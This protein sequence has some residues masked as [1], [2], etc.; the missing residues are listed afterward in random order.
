MTNNHV[1]EGC[2]K[3]E[4]IRTGFKSDAEVVSLDAQ[5]DLA[6]LRSEKSNI[7]SLGF[8]PNNKVRIGENIIV[9]GY[10]LGDLLGSSIKLTSGNIS[11]MTGLIN[12]STTMQL[13]A[14]VQ[15]G[16][17]GGPL[18]DN[19]GQIIGVIFAKLAHQKELNAENINLAIKS[20]IVKMFLDT[21]DISYTSLP[22]E[23]PKEI[24]DIADE[25]KESI[26]RINCYQ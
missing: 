18:L 23:S 8:R 9:L 16:N 25:A 4:L 6:I 13:T 11:S 19:R 15:P 22:V 17:S 20:N 10:P 2:K 12:D 14:P 21:H 3:I 7:K 26:V 1:V 24:V 5:N